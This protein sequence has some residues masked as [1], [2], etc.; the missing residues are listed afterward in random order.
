MTLYRYNISP[1][2]F[3]EETPGEGVSSVNIVKEDDTT[4]K[5]DSI[6]SIAVEIKDE[7]QHIH[8]TISFVIPFI[9]IVAGLLFTIILTSRWGKK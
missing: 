8:T 2:L 7:M 3:T 4:N 6:E 5:Y 1:F 9:G